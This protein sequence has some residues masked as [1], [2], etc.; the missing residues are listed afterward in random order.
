VSTGGPP[1]GRRSDLARRLGTAVVVLPLLFVGMFWAPPAV[2]FAIVTIA[3]ALGA[4]EF[5]ALMRARDLKALRVG[6]AL[7][8]AA[9]YAQ[10]SLG[11]PVSYVLVGAPDA[12]VSGHLSVPL[13]PVAAVVILVALLF[14]ASDFARDVPAAA[15]TLLGA[16]YLGGLGGSIAALCVMAPVEMGPWRIG[17]LMAAVMAGDTAAYFVGRALGRHKLAPSISPGKTV[18]G[19]IGGLLGGVLGA[20]AVSEAGLGLPSTHAAALGG[21]VALAGIAGDLL[22]S[23]LKRWAG[24]KDSGRLFPGHGG[25]LDRLDSLLFGAAVLYYYFSLS[26]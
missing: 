5:D 26:G 20:W 19:A 6:G 18:E 8:L 21:L 22:E 3:V 10:V 7:V 24:V 4:W 12:S 11:W 13:W 9:V 16:V 25:M 17:L 1:T 14:R 15:L 2:G 23:L